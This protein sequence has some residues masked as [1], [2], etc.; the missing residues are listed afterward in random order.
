MRPAGFCETRPEKP[1]RFREMISLLPF[2]FYLFAFLTYCVLH[3]I[4]LTANQ[5][6]GASHGDL[7][8]MR[9]GIAHAGGGFAADQ[10]R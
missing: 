3:A 4:G 8:A 7:A 5:D 2:E 6:C 1:N 10:D 9:G